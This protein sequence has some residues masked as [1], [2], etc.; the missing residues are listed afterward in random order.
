[1]K[2]HKRIRAALL[3]ARI[4]YHWW[5]ILHYRK[6]GENWV[7]CGEPLNT[8]RLLRLS[9]RADFHGLCAKKHEKDY[10]M[11]YVSP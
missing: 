6:R 9:K 11:L 3:A 4:E 1:M 2:L 5:F 8:K 10:E 7:G